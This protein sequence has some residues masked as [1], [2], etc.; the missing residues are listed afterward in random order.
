MGQGFLLRCCI[1]TE[2][3]SSALLGVIDTRYLIYQATL[4]STL[5][6]VWQAG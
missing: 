5:R 3:L 2:H 1:E 6:L 4:G